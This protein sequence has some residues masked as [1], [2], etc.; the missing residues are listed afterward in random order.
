MSTN[1]IRKH[2]YIA[3][4]IAALICTFLTAVGS[5]AAQMAELAEIPAHL[6]MTA[7]VSLSA[8]AG[9]WL[10]RR[11]GLS[12]KE[13]GFRS[14]ASGTVRS[15]WFCVPLLLMEVIPFVAY[16]PAFT[17]PGAEYAALALF[18]IVVGFNEEL[19]FRGLA[20][21]FLAKKSRKQA[22]IGSAVIFGVLHAANALSGTN[23]AEVLLQIAFA[24][25]AGL[26]LALIVSITRSLW[27]GIVWHTVHNFLSF[28]TEVAFDRTALAVLSAQVLILLIFTIGLW[29]RGTE[30]A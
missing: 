28:S 19:Y 20:F 23:P 8:L 10:L 3:V 7:S 15:I 6:V 25:F 13:A 26:V 4:L 11:S 27:I 16:G 2:P 17:R 1:F 21:S 30:A 14:P 9:M 18:T 5:A 12:A 29:K 24:F 22:V